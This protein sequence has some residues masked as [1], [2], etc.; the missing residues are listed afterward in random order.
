[1]NPGYAGRTELPDNLKALFRPVAMTVADQTNIAEI[2]LFCEGF[3]DAS[4]LARR[5]VKC[6]QISSQLLSNQQHYD[7][8]MRTVKAV[9]SR[10]GS[11]KRSSPLQPEASIL[12]QTLCETNVPKL[13]ASDI[14]VISSPPKLLITYRFSK[15]L[16]KF[17]S[18][19]YL[20]ILCWVQ[21]GKFRKL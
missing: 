14:P 20:L 9:L 10:A 18:L 2:M 21:L 17:F 5:L 12:A 6:L 19:K 16:C 1:M 3:Q 13:L 11:V 8:A 7:F 15:I 4:N